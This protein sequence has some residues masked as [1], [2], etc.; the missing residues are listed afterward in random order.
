MRRKNVIIVK[1]LRCLHPAQGFTAGGAPI[2]TPR[3]SLSAWHRLSTTGSTGM[4]PGKLQRIHQPVD[5]RAGQDRAGGIMDQHQTWPIAL[6]R[7]QPET[8]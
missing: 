1:G 6:H 7:F 8:D 3:G 5:H 4:A 2:F